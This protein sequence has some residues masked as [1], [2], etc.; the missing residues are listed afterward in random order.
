MKAL[1]LAGGKGTR[2][3]PLTYTTAKQLIPVANVPILHYVM[4]HLE[5]AEIRDVGVIL[6]PET[7][8]QVRASLESA[9]FSLDFTYILQEA[10]LGLAHAVKVARPFLAGEP[11]VM[12]L[13]DNLIGR[14]IRPLVEEFLHRRA[15]AL[16][17]LKAVSDPTRFGV[18]ELDGTGRVRR[19]SERRRGVPGNRAKRGTNKVRRALGR[20]PASGGAT[21]SGNYGA[22]STWCGEVSRG[23]SPSRGVCANVEQ[24]GRTQVVRPSRG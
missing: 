10:P 7:G 22:D 4:R 12:Y 19:G 5:E 18:A 11:F 2:L 21:E 15:D 20:G 16:V 3:R 6:S 23:K 14:G 1:V 24:R 13:G 17:L 8:D 9:R